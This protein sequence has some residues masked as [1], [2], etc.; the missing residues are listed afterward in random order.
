[1]YILRDAGEHVVANVTAK[2]LALLKYLSIIA[3]AF[4]V[5]SSDIRLFVGFPY[6]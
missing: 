1:M 3:A 5:I 4:L 6:I 2:I